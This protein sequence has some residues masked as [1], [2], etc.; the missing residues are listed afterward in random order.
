MDRGSSL[1]EGSTHSFASVHAESCPAL[2]DPMDCSLPGSSVHGVFQARILKWVAISYSQPRIKPMSP[3]FLLGRQ[4]LLP[5][6][7]WQA[8][9]L[10]LEVSKLAEYIMSNAGLDEAQ[11]RSK[12]S[13][14]NTNNLTY[15]DNT[16]LVAKSEEELRSLLMKV[17]EESEKAGLKLNI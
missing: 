16:T 15:A 17:K 8:P 10:P 5:L 14:R 9:L 2:C 1:F 12:I 6:Y 13:R 4:V 7:R 3:A 11:T